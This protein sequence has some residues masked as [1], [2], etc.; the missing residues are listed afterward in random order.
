[1]HPKPQLLSILFTLVAAVGHTQ[2][3]TLLVGQ[4]EAVSS[5]PLETPFPT[6]SA[7]TARTQY[8][9]PS[10]ELMSLPSLPIEG[11]VLELLDS[12][13]PGTTVDLE[14]RMKNTLMLCIATQDLSGL[15][16]VADT[17]GLALSAGTLTIPFNIAFF[18]WLGPGSGLL[19]DIGMQRTGATGVDPRV[20][21]DTSFV[22]EPTAWVHDPSLM[23]I[24][25][26]TAFNA[27]SNGLLWKRPVL[28]LL[29]STTTAMS[30]G[31][32]AQVAFYPNPTS[33]LLDLRV[34]RG[35]APALVRV[36]DPLGRIVQ[37]LQPS[38]LGNGRF[39]VH[40]DHLASGSYLVVL[41]NEAGANFWQCRVLVR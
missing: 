41:V 21:L 20:L 31:A 33:D 39:Q 16:L 18:N 36:F 5:G 40:F 2:Y 7:V 11:V 6:G 29:T 35:A 24:D 23:G 17:Q 32:E 27:A 4:F 38:A 13:P 10:M 30:A 12:D 19:L 28:G 25:T 3:D 26:M 34:V 14:V 37:D 22:C 15:S 9:L 8:V 1:M